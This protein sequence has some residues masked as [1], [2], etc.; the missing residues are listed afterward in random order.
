[1]RLTGG[2]MTVDY[3]ISEGVEYVFAVPGHKNT[4]LRDAFADREH[5]ITVVPAMHEQGAAHVADGY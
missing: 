3:L 5:E 1:M 4:A 2:Q